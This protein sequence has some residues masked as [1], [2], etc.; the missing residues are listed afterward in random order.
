MEI[1][2]FIQNHMRSDVLDLAMPLI[3]K[4]GDGGLL[5]ILCCLILLLHPKTR[6]AGAVAA[7]SLALEALLC[8]LLLKPLVARPR[9]FDVNPTVTLLIP[10]PH[11]FSFPSGHSGAS[12]ACAAALFF[13]RQKLWPFALALAA[14]IAFSRLYLYVHYPTDVLAGIVLGF[15]T[16][17][18]AKKAVEKWQQKITY[19]AKS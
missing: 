10:R 12:F 15:L 14:L 8:N 1:L 4:L 16:G 11:D 5:W 17:W 19:N 9:P 7:I 2:D 6:R 18:A 3:T 13:V